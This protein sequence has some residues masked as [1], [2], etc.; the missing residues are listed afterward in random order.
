VLSKAILNNIHRS[1]KKETSNFKV[2]EHEL[3]SI[4]SGG[5]SPV[6]RFEEEQEF[7]N[8]YYGIVSEVPSQGDVPKPHS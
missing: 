7:R 8:S 3:K 1:A 5:A 2:L 6:K 4:Y